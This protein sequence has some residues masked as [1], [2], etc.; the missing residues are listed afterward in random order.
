ML[1]NQYIV[2]GGDVQRLEKDIA[3]LIPGAE[4]LIPT[5]TV[6]SRVRRKRGSVVTDKIRHP[7][8]MYAFVSWGSVAD[9]WQRIYRADSCWFVLGE[10]DEE[11]PVLVGA[12]E[13][14][15][16]IGQYNPDMFTG[17]RVL[18]NTALGDVTGDYVDG[19]VK[20]N[21]FNRDLF[22]KVGIERLELV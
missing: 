13:V 3:A 6:K 22:V 2:V 20:V 10:R 4:V 18:V 14:N 11:F 5:V 21:L 19:G 8:Y 16:A 12:A 9:N 17:K 7:F 1:N 15:D